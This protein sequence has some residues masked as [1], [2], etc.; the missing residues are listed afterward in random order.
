MKRQRRSSVYK[1]CLISGKPDQV[2]EVR[3][4]TEVCYHFH[5][6]FCFRSAPKPNYEK[7]KVVR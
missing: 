5:L 2:S 6:S 4:F 1:L 3:D 7:A